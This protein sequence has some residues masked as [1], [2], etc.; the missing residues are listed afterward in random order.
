[1][2]EPRVSEH[3]CSRPTRCAACGGRI[4]VGE[5]MLTIVQRSLVESAHA[6]CPARPSAD[7]AHRLLADLKKEIR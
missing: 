3:V 4:E 1:M 2:T 5:L 7:A 6:D